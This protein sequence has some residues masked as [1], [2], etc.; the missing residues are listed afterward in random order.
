MA[1]LITKAIKEG[2]LTTDTALSA[3]GKVVRDASSTLTTWQRGNA[4]RKLRKLGFHKDAV[5]YLIPSPHHA[6]AESP[7]PEGV[8]SGH[9]IPNLTRGNRDIIRSHGGPLFENTA[10]VHA[11]IEDLFAKTDSQ[12]TKQNNLVAMRAWMRLA[13]AP[14]EMIN[15]TWRP[16]L[17]Q[18]V[19]EQNAARLTNR[20]R[21]GIKLPDAY[22]SPDLLITRLSEA[23][24]VSPA[25]LADLSV[26][27][28]ARPAEMRPGG[29]TLELTPWGVEIKGV[30]KKRG[31]AAEEKYPLVTGAVGCEPNIVF[32]FNKFRALP[33][34]VQLAMCRAMATFT[35]ESYGLPPKYLRIF[36]AELAVRTS[37]A[38]NGTKRCEVRSKALRH[39]R[40]ITA[41]SYYGIV[42]DNVV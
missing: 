21:V 32:I 26:A 30:K 18:D 37:K 35:R 25:V 2:G 4:R 31:A 3:P 19:N 9:K 22:S 10:S 8:P 27:L 17:T 39:K 34:A 11:C 16:K 42:E 13:N 14:D 29:I 36:G 7:N 40:T 5:L 28:C 20:A 15:A 41:T 38:N 33:E 6:Q 24:D 23:R 1:R 12:A